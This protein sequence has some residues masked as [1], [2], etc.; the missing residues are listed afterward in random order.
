MKQTLCDLCKLAANFIK[1]YVDNNNTEAEVKEALD[2][3]C[4]L[5]PSSVSKEVSNTDLHVCGQCVYVLHI[6]YNH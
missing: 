1:P 4:G 3:V 5:L 6:L 2:T